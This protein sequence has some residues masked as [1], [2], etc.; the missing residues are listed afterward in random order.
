MCQYVEYRLK[1]LV[2]EKEI[3]IEG[4]NVS[5]FID[6]EWIKAEK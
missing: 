2:S 4:E 5:S 6:K 3:A 1:E